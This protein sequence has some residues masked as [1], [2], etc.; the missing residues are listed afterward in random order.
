MVGRTRSLIMLLAI[1]PLMG[2]CPLRA[3][4]DE[5]KPVTIPAKAQDSSIAKGASPALG[6]AMALGREFISACHSPEAP[7]DPC[8]PGLY[9]DWRE[10]S[11]HNRE[12]FT[13]TRFKGA[14]IVI[15]HKTF[16]LVLQGV[17]SDGSVEDVYETHVALGDAET[18]TPGGSFV[19][20][21]IY[22]YPDV[23]FFDSSQEKIPALYKGFFAPLLACDEHGN[24]ERFR[25]L[26][27][28]GF[29]PS[30]Y[31]Q[32]DR[33]RPETF[34][35][36]SGGCIRLPD[37]CQFKTALIRLVGLGPLRKNDRGCY[38][39]LN[40]PVEVRISEDDG[41]LASILDGGLLQVRRGLRT[42]MGIFMP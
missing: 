20:N 23:V 15:D 35:A 9:R 17:L 38:H 18:P 4:S 13:E 31:P 37:P 6:S 24:C 30:A 40:K 26:G 8:L 22:C 14:R 27:M 10:L 34:G 42:L 12:G 41:I 21:H 36:V 11:I 19:I 33:I 5:A 32:P 29:E 1:L 2:V 7:P 3:A 39:W 16:Q 25:E 28:H